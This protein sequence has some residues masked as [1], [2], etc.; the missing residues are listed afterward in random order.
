M[1]LYPLKLTTITRPKIWGEEIWH[2]VQM[3]DLLSVVENGYLAENDLGELLEVYMGDLVGD[4]VYEQ[5]GNTFPL[6]LK[7]INTFDDL[8]IQV[9]PGDEVALRDHNCL[10]KTEMW[11]VVDAEP[12]TTLISG[13]CQDTDAENIR[14]AIKDGN[15]TDLLNIVPVK[16]GNVVFL[17]SGRVHALRKGISVAEIQ[18]NSDLTYR[19]FDYNRVPKEGISRPLH[20]EQALNVLDFKKL[21]QPLTDYT[22]V[23]NGAVK[24]AESD[25][26]VTNLLRFNRK[27]GR[28]YAPLD[29]FVVYMC[30]EGGADVSAEGETV[31]LKKGDTVLIPA[32]LDEVMLTPQGKT[33]FLEIYV[34]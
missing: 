4:H 17:P 2:M 34:P 24:I 33:R 14:S 23:E 1:N 10:G 9:H 21:Q 8:S 28:D 19:L 16:K 32:S 22:P 31:T 18:E 15:L 25:Y 29:S 5:Y 20:V 12:D 27:I 7:I 13:F 30:V 6:L 11:Y 26:F 3:D